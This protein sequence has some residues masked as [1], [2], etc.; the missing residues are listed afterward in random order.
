MKCL[1]SMAIKIHFM[2]EQLSLRLLRLSKTAAA[3]RGGQASPQCL[4]F[5]VL[6][7]VLFALSLP[8]WCSVRY[9][10][11]AS[12]E[13]NQQT[14]IHARVCS[15]THPGLLSFDT[16]NNKRQCVYSHYHQSLLCH[17]GNMPLKPQEPATRQEPLQ[18]QVTLVVSNM[19][20]PLKPSELTTVK[21]I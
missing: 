5:P 9:F 20:K 11:M 8:C 10:P 19:A 7:V 17:C 21:S 3:L 12:L 15:T 16:S 1:N 14:N 6:F 18:S 2:M 13:S 4:S